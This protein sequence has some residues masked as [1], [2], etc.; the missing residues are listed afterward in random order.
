MLL[1]YEQVKSQPVNALNRDCSDHRLW[2]RGLVR[3]STWLTLFCVRCYALYTKFPP[4][5]Y[6][7]VSKDKVICDFWHIDTSTL[8][9]SSCRDATKN[10]RRL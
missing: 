1:R 9:F 6:V 4:V 8:F 7:S 2:W 10:N 5:F 3:V